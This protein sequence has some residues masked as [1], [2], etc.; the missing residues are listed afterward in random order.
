MAGTPVLSLRLWV[1]GNTGLECLKVI[2]RIFVPCRF[3]GL[4]TFILFLYIFIFKQ[5]ALSHD[6]S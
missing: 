2:V 4:Q 3:T 6:V 5:Y 1:W